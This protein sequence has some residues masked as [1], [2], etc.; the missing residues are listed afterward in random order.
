[1][2]AQ[3]QQRL[4]QAIRRVA[5]GGFDRFES[6]HPTADGSLGHFNFFLTPIR[7]ASGQVIYLVPEVPR[8]HRTQAHRAHAV[9]RPSSA[10]VPSA[11][12]PCWGCSPP[13]RKAMS[14]I[15]RAVPAKS[16]AS[17]SPMRSPGAPPRA[18]TPT[19]WPS[20][21]CNGAMPSWSA[22]PLPASGA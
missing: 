17:A 22:S 9:R 7:D 20:T 8:H 19:T 6:T 11:R 16:P 15:S 14:R 12:V 5:A 10:S 1:M 3:Q 4:R 13:I 18:C 2:I 21:D